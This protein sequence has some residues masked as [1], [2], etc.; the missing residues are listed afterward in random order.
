MVTSRPGLVGV[1]N[2]GRRPSRQVMLTLPETHRVSG[3]EEA[4][5]FWTHPAPPTLTPNPAAQQEVRG[6]HVA[7]VPRQTAPA[8][9]AG[10]EQEASKI[11][12]K[13]EGKVAQEILKLQSHGVQR[14]HESQFTG[15]TEIFHSEI[16]PP[17]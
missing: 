3:G 7:P 17:A 4:L 1:H 6:P 8:A 11:C 16:R 12:L 10:L 15:L 14:T 13:A 5:G 2:R 9:R